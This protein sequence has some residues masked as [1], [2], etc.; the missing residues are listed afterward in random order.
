M[1]DC[2]LDY[3]DDTFHSTVHCGHHSHLIL[4][5]RTSSGPRPLQEPIS[6]LVFKDPSSVASVPTVI[7]HL[8]RRAAT[9]L[10]KDTG[11]PLTNLFISHSCGERCICPLDPPGAGE[12]VLHDKPTLVL[13]FP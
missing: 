8:Q 3:S 13:Q 11:V 5:L 12:Q 4:L 7:F 2:E 9:E 10:F 1:C 6:P